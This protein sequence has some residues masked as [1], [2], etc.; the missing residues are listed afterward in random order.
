MTTKAKPSKKPKRVGVQVGIR[1]LKS[2][3]KETQDAM[4]EGGK[5]AARVWNDCV[6][7]FY[8]AMKERKSWP[9]W[10]ELR[11]FTKRK[12]W[13]H[14]Q[15]VQ[16]VAK[17]V[18]VAFATT[19]QLR[20]THPKMGMRYPHKKK[21]VYSLMW[22]AQAVE[23]IGNTVV[24]PMGNGRK[25]LILEFN[26]DLPFIGGA[27]KVVWSGGWE[28]HVT[29]R[30]EEKPEPSPGA[31]MATG[32]LG[33]IHQI[34]VVTST[35]EALVVS[36]RK[37]RAIKRRRCMELGKIASK[38]SKCKKGSKRDKKLGRARRKLS[39]RTRYQV[40]DLRHKGLRSVINFCVNQ[41]VGSLYVG[42]PHGVRSRNCGA[43]HNGRMAR[44]E[45]GLDLNLLEHKAKKEG[46]EFKQGTERGTSSHCPACDNKQRPVGRNF[47]CKKCK[48][49]VH[50]DL[51]GGVNMHPIGFGQKVPL[52]TAIK[53][54]RPCEGFVRNLRKKA[55]GNENPVAESSSRPATG[56]LTNS[57][58]LSCCGAGEF[59]KTNSL[60]PQLHVGTR[61]QAPALDGIN[62]SGQGRSRACSQAC[63]ESQETTPMN[64]S[65]VVTFE[66]FSY[67]F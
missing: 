41:K 35:G 25:D 39:Q 50:R 33:E 37:I 46:I 40:R 38:S 7:L 42:N 31:V 29:S 52:P 12:Y 44:W 55:T 19:R 65:R 64:G 27:C 36:G 15:T 26:G 3:P 28:L 6:E 34:A 16:A 51:M 20:K 9:S 57:K 66:D 13:L 22:P 53:Y 67:F 54:L 49:T 45:Y 14:S 59:G 21:Y 8:T 48:V 24:L 63:P 62:P 4:W 5:E 47:T 58:L 2:L 1:P 32:D 61:I 43:V 60:K 17:S 23:F 56:L 18:Q 30:G 11:R 10:K